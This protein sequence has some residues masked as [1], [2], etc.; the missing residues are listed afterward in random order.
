MP[1]KILIFFCLYCSLSVSLADQI[2]CNGNIKIKDGKNK[3]HDASVGLR[4]SRDDSNTLSII[5]DK[6]KTFVIAYPWMSIQT[7]IL[8]NSKEQ[9][10]QKLKVDS[11]GMNWFSVKRV[12]L[13]GK[14]ESV[15]CTIEETAND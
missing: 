2:N 13:L 8:L 15:N 3:I 12:A 11:D 6:N 10:K 9:K 1:L 4:I 14:K 5:D 7:K